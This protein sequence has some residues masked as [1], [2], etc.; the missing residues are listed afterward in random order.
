MVKLSCCLEEVIIFLLSIGEI[1]FL[2]GDKFKLWICLVFI[3][4][5]IVILFLDNYKFFFIVSFK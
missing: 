3:A 5:V 4:I 1:I 2:N